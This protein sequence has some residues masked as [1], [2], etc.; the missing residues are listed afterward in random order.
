MLP[1]AVRTLKY[2]H[3]TGGRFNDDGHLNLQD[4]DKAAALATA[5][6]RTLS[7]GGRAD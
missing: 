6:Q 7:K 3:M 2:A 4:R 5:V 1:D